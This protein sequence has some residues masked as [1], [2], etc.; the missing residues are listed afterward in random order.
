MSG[1]L[2]E[3]PNSFL[4]G[5]HKITVHVNSEVAFDK[6]GEWIVTNNTI[7]LWP[8]GNSRNFML[9][10]FLH[11]LCHAIEDIFGTHPDEEKRVDMMAQGLMQF[12]KT[13]KY[14]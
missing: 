7:R 13:A 9:Q 6:S 10:T 3:I 5:G 4:L 8:K 2:S 14:K 11:E 1:K 12:A